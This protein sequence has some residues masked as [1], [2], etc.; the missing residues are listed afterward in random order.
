AITRKP[1]SANRMLVSALELVTQRELH[2]PGGGGTG[3]LAKRAGTCQSERCRRRCEVTRI[4]EVHIVE[5][6]KCF[7]AELNPLTFPRQQEEFAHSQV[8]VREPRSADNVPRTNGAGI[9]PHEALVRVRVA[10]ETRSPRLVISHPIRRHRCAR[11]Q[12][13]DCRDQ[14]I[15]REYASILDTQRLAP[16]VLHQ[17]RYLPTSDNLIGPS[18]NVGQD[19]LSWAERQF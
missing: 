11:A 17:R 12:D 14:V 13:R 15:R 5:N 2:H 7:G 6:I 16:P 3:E 10:K 8:N 9:L 19:R 18:G 4:V 1:A